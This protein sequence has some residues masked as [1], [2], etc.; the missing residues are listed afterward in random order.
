[1]KN[2]GELYREKITELKKLRHKDSDEYF[3]L[4]KDVEKQYGIS[5]KTIYRDMNKK[6]PGLRKRRNDLGTI[7]SRITKN[8]IL[9]AEEIMSSGKQIKKAK[10]IIEKKTSKKISQRKMG[11]IK[12][13]AMNKEENNFSVFGGE[14]KKFFEN[15]FEYD[16]ISPEKGIP[17]KYN[18]VS[19][20]VKKDDL[21][22]I[23]MI[24]SNAYNRGCFEDKNKLKLDRSSLRNVMMQHLIEDLMKVASD[25]SDFKL[26]ESL[27]RMIDRMNV[28]SQLP[29]DFETVLKVC[30]ELKADISKDDVIN[31][32]KKVVD[33]ED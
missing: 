33:E 7:K 13:A 11:R 12:E 32:I 26:V 14:A 23:I 31:I 30:K 21:R 25:A 17:L 2:R 5:K 4:M 15:I 9:I 16:L 3:N 8:E 28:D 1:M 10:E 22:D 20:I 27:T 19:F 18:G 24:L 29:A 6:V